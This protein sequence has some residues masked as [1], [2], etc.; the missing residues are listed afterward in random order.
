[1]ATKIMDG[2]VDHPRA[3]SSGRQITF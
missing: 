2:L 3:R 1:M